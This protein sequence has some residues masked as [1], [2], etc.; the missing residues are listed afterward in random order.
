MEIAPNRPIYIY[1]GT[2]RKKY[3]GDVNFNKDA[4]E[5]AGNLQNYTEDID[6]V[7][8][9]QNGA[10]DGDGDSDGKFNINRELLKMMKLN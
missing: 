1:D 4:A 9:L 7:I 3:D 8:M 10:V 6:K 2:G 5:K